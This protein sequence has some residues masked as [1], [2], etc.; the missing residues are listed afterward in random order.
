MGMKKKNLA[1]LTPGPL[2][3]FRWEPGFWHDRVATNRR[4]TVPVCYRK[5]EETG[6][7]ENWRLDWQPDQERPHFFWDSDCAKWIEAAAYCL[8]TRRDRRLE[9]RIEGLIDLIEAAQQPDGYLNTYFTAVEPERR[10]TNL[11]YMHE[12]YCAGHLM[13]AAVA[14][15]QATGRRRLLDVMCR[16][17][18]HIDTVFGPKTGQLPGYDGHPEIELAL[19]RLAEATGEARYAD[20]ARFFVDERGRQPHFFDLEGE[21]QKRAIAWDNRPAMDIY[22]TYQAHKPVREQENAVGHSVRACYL[23]AG[24]ADVAV[25]TGD[26]ELIKACRRLWRSM[27]ERRMYVTGGIGSSRFAEEFT[28]DYD[29]PNEDAYAETCASIAL[30]FFAHRMLQI[31]VDGRYADVMERALY[32]GVISGVSLDGKRF[33]YDNLL[34]VH[35]ERY[36]YSRQ[37]PT[38]RQE[39]FGCACCPPNLAR[40]LASLGCY[41][42]STGRGAIYLHLYGSSRTRLEVSG[43][44]VG[45]RQETEYPW[46]GKI[47]LSL[48]P[49]QPTAFK[50]ALRVPGWCR[51]CKLKVNG[52][53]VKTPAVNKGYATIER[54]W[55]AG[56]TVEID[57][58]MPVERVEAHPSVRQDC[59]MVALQ[60]G[61]IV[62]CLEACDN[63]P[64]LADL[65]LP[66]RSKLHLKKRDIAGCKI[67]TIE[68]EARRRDRRG[69]T[70]SLYRS[71]PS[72]L[73]KAKIRAVPYFM[74]DNRGDG[75]EMRV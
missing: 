53:R 33:F 26:R 3:V 22:R 24:M 13:E 55:Q 23:Y 50:L 75:G 34:E 71:D 47:R 36:P 44:R 4:S 28:F 12:L 18:D 35:P 9:D 27:T 70:G 7:I 61:P 14:Y 63:G 65:S 51:R 2:A 8:A 59:G 66:D 32:N 11:M 42:W 20:L 69:W 6:R 21:K 54:I 39:W 43:V 1:R 37:K 31:D 52:S 58:E 17:A 5:L 30:V 56:D 16:Y 60:R 68:A 49:E 41:A 48:A 45:L 72:P 46:D 73:R 25:A 64:D 15:F 62:Y 29:L 19:M 67:P 38:Y 74:W 10:W 40:L 57:L